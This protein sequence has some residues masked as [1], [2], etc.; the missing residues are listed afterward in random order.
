MPPI[1]I[2]AA[3]LALC[4]QAHTDCTG[5]TKNDFLAM[6]SLLGMSSSMEIL[7]TGPRAKRDVDGMCDVDIN[8]RGYSHNLAGVP[9]AVY[10][11]PQPEGWRAVHG[12]V[13]EIKT[14]HW[15]TGFL[16]IKP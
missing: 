13:Q 4:A 10:L 15:G 2:L 12:V 16:C 8:V 3:G 1:K 5:I 11:Y 14:K 6:A 7:E 9:T